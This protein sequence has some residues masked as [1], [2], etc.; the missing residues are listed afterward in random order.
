MRLTGL[1]ELYAL[2]S[3]SVCMLIGSALSF[4]QTQP[5][6]TPKSDFNVAPP[7]DEIMGKDAASRKASTSQVGSPDRTVGPQLD[8]SIVA[9]DNQTLTPA[10]KII[11]LGSPVRAKAIAL[12]PN[13]TAHSAAVLLMGS[14]QPV[15]VFDTVTGQVLQ[16]F[17]PTDATTISVKDRTA[18]SFTGITYSADGSKLLF[19]QDNNYIVIAN[20]NGKTGTL[21]N[22]HRVSLPEPPADGR[23]YHN[24]RSINPGGIA[25]SDDGRHAYVALNAANTLGVIDL[26]ASPAKLIGQIPV[27]NAPNSVAFRGN[28]AYVTNEGGR[29]ATGADFTNLSDGTRS[30]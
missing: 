10:G 30:S 5:P 26:T 13:R 8:G 29:P 3:V 4:S 21:R 23:P 12:N 18:G 16:R 1:V 9:S 19:S 22:E 28:Y 7:K 17:T 24:P 14:P 6:Q 27:G 25:L 20:V 11:E 2:R 15:I